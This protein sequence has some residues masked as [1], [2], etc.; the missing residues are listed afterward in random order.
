MEM[1]N[2]IW[3]DETHGH[4]HVYVSLDGHGAVVLFVDPQTHSAIRLY[5]FD[6]FVNKLPEIL[7]KPFLEAYE[8]LMAGRGTPKP[9]RAISTP[10]FP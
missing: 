7:R 1:V 10:F 8:R 6:A 9:T 5:Q 2:V 3:E 4:V